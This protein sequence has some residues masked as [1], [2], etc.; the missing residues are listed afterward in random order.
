MNR[1]TRQRSRQPQ[2]TPIGGEFAP[3]H[4]GG[5][6][7]SLEVDGLAFA[8]GGPDDGEEFKYT[9]ADIVN[10]AMERSDWCYD[11]AI[12]HTGSREMS[13]ELDLTDSDVSG[14]EVPAI[15]VDEKNRLKKELPD[16]VISVK[17][18]AESSRKRMMEDSSVA[19]FLDDE[20][21][22]PVDADSLGGK[23]QFSGRYAIR[24]ATADHP[25]QLKDLPDNVPYLAY[26][27]DGECLD[28][29][30]GWEVYSGN[31]G[32]ATGDPVMHD[33]EYLGGQLAK[34]MLRDG[35]V[36]ALRT[37]DWYNETD[38]GYLTEGWVVYRAEESSCVR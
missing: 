27:V 31:H 25:A 23:M 32:K 22:E 33:S 11:D 16:W 8:Y 18:S 30:P 36:Y 10:L 12:V 19:I 2:G 1:N 20:Y 38:G 14:D 28:A 13:V 6:A 9:E 24:P 5:P 35:G 3:E 7:T 4:D 21:W 34:D 37:V 15:L 29:F 17:E 26:N